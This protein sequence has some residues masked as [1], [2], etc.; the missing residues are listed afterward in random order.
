MLSEVSPYFDRKR[1][2]SVVRT[3]FDIYVFIKSIHLDH[4]KDEENDHCMNIYDSFC[5]YKR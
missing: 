4:A 3:K 5:E 2:L 1:Y